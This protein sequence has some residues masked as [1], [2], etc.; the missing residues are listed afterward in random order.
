[1]AV[2]TISDARNGG[3]EGVGG[4]ATVSVLVSEPD[5]MNTHIEN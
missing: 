1:M 3:V 2:D 4:L 5:K